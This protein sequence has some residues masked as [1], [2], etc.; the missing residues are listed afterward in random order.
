M[1]KG[2]TKRF[3]EYLAKQNDKRIFKDAF[4]LLNRALEKQRT[5]TIDMCWPLVTTSP[6]YH[7]NHEQALI[8]SAVASDNV[9][10][11]KKTLNGKNADVWFSQSSPLVPEGPHHYTREHILHRAINTGKKNIALFLAQQPET[12][13]LAE[14]YS[15]TTVYVTGRFMGASGHVSTNVQAHL[16]PLEAARKKGMQEVVDVLAE[17]VKTAVP[18]SKK[19]PKSTPEPRRI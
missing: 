10:L 18:K 11:L 17:R 9:D 6:F 5:E 13:V 14:G 15:Q 8:Q 4:I 7:A 19:P 2:L 16:P 1:F 12:D 3:N